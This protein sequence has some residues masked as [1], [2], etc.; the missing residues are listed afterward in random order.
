MKKL[1]IREIAKMAG[2]SPSAV[3]FVL[4]NKEGVSL[5]TREKIKEVIRRTNFTP[6]MNSRRLF[7][8]KSFNITMATKQTSSPFSNLFYFEAAKGVLE[9]SKEFNYNV[10]FT[11]VGDSPKW[12]QSLLSSINSNDTDGIIFFQDTDFALL[13]EIERL[14]VPYVVLDCHSK[15]KKFTYVNADSELASYVAT[16]YLTQNGHKKIAFI[17]SC[18]LPEYYLQTFNGFK[19]AIDKLNTELPSAWIQNTAT[20]EKDAYLCMQ[21]ILDS[22][23]LPTAVFCAGDIYAIGAIKCAKANGYKVPEDISFIG[24]DDILLSGY[25]EPALTTVRIEPVKM[26][27]L[28]MQLLMQKIG[29]EHPLGITVESDKLIIRDSVRQL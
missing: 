8:K 15:E 20:D 1:T 10:V 18:Y 21:K 11:E 23:A 17:G 6:D 5:K 16:S 24:I 19:S 25:I 13:K 29:G 3:S 14:N 22:K 9:K 26:G 7:F 27:A 4:N 2:V 12:W 28:A